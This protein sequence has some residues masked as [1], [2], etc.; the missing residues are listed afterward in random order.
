M[1]PTL[2][3]IIA[4]TLLAGYAVYDK[5]VVFEHVTDELVLAFVSRG[6]IFLL[7]TPFLLLPAVSLP[8]P[9]M[10]A[11]SIMTGFIY[12]LSSLIYFTGVKKGDPSTMIVFLNSKPAL[13]VIAA[14]FLLG[15]VLQAVQY[16]GIAVVVGATLLLSVSRIEGELKLRETA[17]YGAAFAVV[18]AAIDLVAK[19]GIGSV[20]P[21]AFFGLAG[22]GQGI[23][24]VGGLTYLYSR[25]PEVLRENTSYEGLRAIAVRSVMFVAGLTLFY[26]ALASTPV[27][28]ASSIVATQTALTV[29]FIWII[30][31]FQGADVVNLG[32]VPFTVKF[33]S[34]LGIMAGV[35][36][37]SR[38]EIVM[39]G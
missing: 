36:L 31:R 14:A 28:I 16:V 17:R 35:T 2:M 6:M 4:A 34:A 5:L 20:E 10:A 23:G 30:T 22:I 15:E 25:R 9:R 38:P 21:L 29:L 37:I 24:A 3:L 12:I 7:V 11:V 18:V 26:V 8:G 1:N 27:S 32:D 13:V 19:Y 33:L 39:A